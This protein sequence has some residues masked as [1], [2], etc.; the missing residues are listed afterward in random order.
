MISTVVWI[1]FL[2]FRAALNPP[3]RSA[4][5]S[6][7]RWQSLPSATVPQDLVPWCAM[8]PENVGENS[9]IQWFIIAVIEYLHACLCMYIYIERECVCVCLCVSI[10]LPFGECTPHFQTHWWWASKLGD[11]FLDRSTSTLFAIGQKGTEIRPLCRWT[12]G[13]ILASKTQELTPSTPQS[14]GWF[15]CTVCMLYAPGPATPPSPKKCKKKTQFIEVF[16]FNY[17]RLNTDF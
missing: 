2:T 4:S 3:R 5:H 12:A 9:Q 13:E 11:F 14:H 16:N 6:K 7:V 10:E 17:N 8:V 15:M 1:K